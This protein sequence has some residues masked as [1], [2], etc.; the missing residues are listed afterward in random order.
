V[1]PL[2]TYRR[3]GKSQGERTW[4]DYERCVAGAPPSKEGPGPDRSM[5]DFFWC[6][7]AAQR[8]W[9]PDETANK[10]LQVSSKAQERARLLDQGYA[11]ITAENAAA[12]AERASRGAGEALGIDDHASNLLARNRASRSFLPLRHKL[13]CT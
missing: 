2:R 9:A 12:A 8:G 1:I 4:P 11:L 6:M 13:E 5:A 7:V 10:L 3:S